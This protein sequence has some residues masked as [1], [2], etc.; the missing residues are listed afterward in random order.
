MD[1]GCGGIDGVERRE[2]CEDGAVNGVV[3]ALVVW[4]AWLDG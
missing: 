2:L 3:E 1:T 4:L